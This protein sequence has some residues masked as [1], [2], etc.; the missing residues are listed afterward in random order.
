MNRIVLKLGGIMMSLI[1]AVLLPLGFV[2]DKI[3]TNFYY[4]QIQEE[5]RELSKKYANT[6]T[7]LNDETMINMFKNLA[8]FT[9]KEIYITDAS[10]KIIADTGIQVN[11]L[12]NN[13]LK[14]LSEGE[15]IQKNVEDRKTNDHYMGY[16]HPIMLSNTFQGSFLS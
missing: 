3:F 12:S 7:S 11:R 1:L 15:S 6:I 8:Y 16:G 4:N 5:I 14:Q 10:G 2:A 13:E 9:N